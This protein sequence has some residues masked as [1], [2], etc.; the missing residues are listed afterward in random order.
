MDDVELS[1]RKALA[2]LGTVGAASAGAGLG[3]SAF[4]GDEESFDN[5]QLTAGT[6][7]LK[8]G[9]AEHYSDWGEDE[10]DHAHVADG[11]LVL[12]DP[13]AFLNATLREQFPDER[14]RR[15]LNRGTVE[16]C[17]A[18]GDVPDDLAKPMIDLTDVKPGDFGEVTFDL[19]PCTN[20]GYVWLNGRLL[21]TTENGVTEPEADATGEDGDAD[22][23]DPADV[24]LLDAVD[25]TVWNDHDCN[26]LRDQ[27]CD[28][29]TGSGPSDDVVKRADID[30]DDAAETVRVTQDV[31]GL[32]DRV[33]GGVVVGCGPNTQPNV[34]TTAGGALPS[35]DNDDDDAEVIVLSKDLPVGLVRIGHVDAPGDEDPDV[36][37]V[38]IDED[39]NCR[40][41]EVA[42]R[43]ADQL[44]PGA[45]GDDNPAT[46][47]S[48]QPEEKEVT[49]LVPEDPKGFRRDANVDPADDREEGGPDVRETDWDIEW[50][51]T[52]KDE[53]TVFSGT[54]REV[55]ELLEQGLGIP[56]DGT[57]ITP[58]DEVDDGVLDDGVDPDRECFAPEARHCIGIRWE[59]PRDA[60]NAVQSDAVVFDLGFYAEQCRR[61]D[62]SGMNGDAVGDGGAPGA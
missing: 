19:V 36:V 23:T 3:T 57:P 26:N 34:V 40:V 53:P 54:L 21:E 4:F 32:I 17:E 24:E 59:L 22:T 2:A 7:D 49:I 25:V 58:F 45:A 10:A 12:D 38:G 27:F 33:A 61:N 52:G 29:E 13:Q 11:D 62:G 16:P 31:A 44:T 9:W 8:V 51:F 37:V 14:T 60:G 35:I 18:F 56:L 39:C 5:N 46:R 55:I 47:V 30:G 15:F 48:E 43:I 50:V 28:V 1:R 41:S 42:V 6:L 20:P